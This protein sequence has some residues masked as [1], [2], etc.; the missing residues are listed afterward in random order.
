M[1]RNGL[2]ADFMNPNSELQHARTSLK[3][4][5][6]TYRNGCQQPQRRRRPT[7][8]WRALQLQLLRQNGRQVRAAPHQC[9]SEKSIARCMRTLEPRE[10]LSNARKTACSQMQKGTRGLLKQPHGRSPL[11]FGPWFHEAG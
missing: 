11:D 3:L 7:V 8:P 10:T 6:T 1:T 5:R 9:S 4:C 2:D